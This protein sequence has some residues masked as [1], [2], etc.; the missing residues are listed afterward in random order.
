MIGYVDPEDRDNENGRNIYDDIVLDELGMPL[1]VW[2]EDSIIQDIR[3][4]IRESGL[5]VQLVAERSKA[6]REI[7]RQDIELMVEDDE[8]IVPGSVEMYPYD[9]ELLE[10]EMAYI[11]EANTYEF[12]TISLEMK[13]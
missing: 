7:I 6:R 4:M 13:V 2:N 1:F 8:R 11:L 5:L 9:V 12:G 10:G 3:H